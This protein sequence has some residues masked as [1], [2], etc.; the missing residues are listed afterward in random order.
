MASIALEKKDFTKSSCNILQKNSGQNIFE[1]YDKYMLYTV[2][3]NEIY[4]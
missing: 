2:K 1:K 3:L 4:F